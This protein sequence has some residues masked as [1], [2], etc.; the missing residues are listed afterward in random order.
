[1]H[2]WLIVKNYK[3]LIM[4]SCMNIRVLIFILCIFT[5][6][7]PA[8]YAQIDPTTIPGPDN[9]AWYPDILSDLDRI[10]ELGE[11]SASVWE[12]SRKNF[13]WTG[14]ILRVREFHEQYLDMNYF[15]VYP[16]GYPAPAPKYGT[17]SPDGFVVSLH[18][19]FTIHYSSVS[20]DHHFGR[21]PAGL[22]IRWS[23]GPTEMIP[24]NPPDGLPVYWD[25]NQYTW[26]LGDDDLRAVIQTVPDG[27][28]GDPQ[29]MVVAGD[30]AI[31]DDVLFLII[32]KGDRLTIMDI[33][34]GR[35]N[36]YSLT[37]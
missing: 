18:R 36:N 6:I 34:N 28:D 22:E 16:F 21:Y 27:E 14:I 3:S 24:V 9:R 11:A 1:M 35:V 31:T 26:H 23:G 5:A 37:R 20:F 7:T 33:R 2:I 25:K 19:E 13:D 32:R 17:N 8:S 30:P 15:G 4:A 10:N 12:F 29:Q